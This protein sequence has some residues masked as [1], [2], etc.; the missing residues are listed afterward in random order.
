MTTQIFSSAEFKNVWS[1]TSS[2]PIFVRDVCRHN[3]ASLN[4]TLLYVLRF[5][6]K[7][8]IS[9][10]KRI[11]RLVFV[12]GKRCVFYEVGAEFINNT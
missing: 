6:Q 1:Y 4:S 9:L 8:S 5:L 11:N 7:T 2:S 10:L 12:M 3:L